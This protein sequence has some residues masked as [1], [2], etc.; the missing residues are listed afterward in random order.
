MS[1]VE[2]IQKTYIY[3]KHTVLGRG[4]EGGYPV[5]LKKI[6]IGSVGTLSTFRHP[7]ACGFPFYNVNILAGI[8]IK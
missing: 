1:S 4:G 8:G 6:K 7:L 2:N 3:G 5:G